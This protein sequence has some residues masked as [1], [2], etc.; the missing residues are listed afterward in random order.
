VL[1]SRA[2]PGL[3]ADGRALELRSGSRRS[4]IVIAVSVA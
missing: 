4:S 1:L 2:V 3:S